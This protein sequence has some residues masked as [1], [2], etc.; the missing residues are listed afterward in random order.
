MAVKAQ[1]IFL[2]G[3]TGYIGSRLIPIL[4]ARG[5]Q[6]AALIREQ[7]RHKLPPFCEAV[8]GSALDGNSYAAAVEGADTFIHL[9]GVPHPSPAKARQFI[10]ID[11]KSAGEAIRVASAAHIRH[12]IYMSVAHPA[13]VMRAYVEARAAGEQ[14]LRESGLNA[15]IL[16]PWYVL[17]PGH[18]WPYLLLPL[19]GIARI[20][21]AT[22]DSARRLAPVT[23]QQVLRSI[24]AAVEDPPGCVRVIEAPQMSTT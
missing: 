12:F 21:P 20:F 23:L 6:V 3:S 1:R 22:R 14:L 19:Y 18:R 5:H 7:S 9:I 8:S 13:P 16:R 10:E 15:T 4:T 2:T 17:G 11:L 24:A